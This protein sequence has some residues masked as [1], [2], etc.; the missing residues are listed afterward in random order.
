MASDQASPDLKPVSTSWS[1]G[2]TRT[3]DG[4]PARVAVELLKVLNER[5]GQGFDTSLRA[6]PDA[7][8]IQDDLAIDDHGG[9]PIVD[10]RLSTLNDV[11]LLLEIVV[12]VD[13]AGLELLGDAGLTSPRTI[14][15]VAPPD[16]LEGTRGEDSVL[17]DDGFGRVIPT[18]VRHGE[19][20]RTAGAN[21]GGGCSDVL[22]SFRF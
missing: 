12:L 10:D 18:R 21:R 13:G 3:Y 16:V 6:L 4:S 1:M 20:R 7:W 2:G 11:H 14:Y 22:V 15:V 19:G 8:C 5:L 17:V 9:V